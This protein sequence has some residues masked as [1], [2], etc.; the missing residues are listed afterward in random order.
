MDTE[1][2]HLSL[3]V[4]RKKKME[5]QMEVVLRMMPPHH[6]GIG[7]DSFLLQTYFNLKPTETEVE[8]NLKL[9]NHCEV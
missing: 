5:L 3:K 6:E 2:E 4:I 1:V 9:H 8:E 7:T